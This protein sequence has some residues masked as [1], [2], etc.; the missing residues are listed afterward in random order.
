MLAGRRGQAWRHQ[1]A[2][3]RPRHFHLEPEI[4]LITRG[5][6]VIGIGDRQL[7][8]TEGQ[9]VVFQAGQDHELI[10]ASHDLG[11]FVV[12]LRPELAE[13]ALGTTALPGIEQSLVSASELTQLDAELSAFGELQDATSVDQR[14]ADL[15]RLTLE[16][17]PKA[18]AL[19]R[20][21]VESLRSDHSLSQSA[22]A[23][24]FRT[25]S[26]N[27]SQDFRR[28]LGVP[29]VEYRARLRLMRFI[30][31]VDRGASLSRAAF[32]ADFGSYAQCHRVF[33]RA[34]RC[35][36]QEYFG[37]LRDQLNDET[38][39]PLEASFA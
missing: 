4:N 22:L 2:F 38:T 7:R 24:R 34:L 14:I 25:T 35:S 36:P 29:L 33:R 20:R 5:S 15:F 6:C 30:D 3:R 39:A 11:L 1:P 18:P 27:I 10:E 19:S 32:D 13:R 31:L 23:H 37:G 12:A 17:A 16:R 8:L 9:F 26:S 28:A 21:A